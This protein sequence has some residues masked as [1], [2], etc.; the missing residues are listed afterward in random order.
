MQHLDKIFTEIYDQYVD[1]VFRFI[2]LKVSSQEI[3]QDLCSEVFL[4]YWKSLNLGTQIENPR[5]FLYQIAR[6]LVIDHYREKGK[7]P[8]IVPVENVRLVDSR[9]NLEKKFALKSDIDGI[10][11]ALNDLKDEYQD[12]I[13]WHYLEDFSISEIAEMM[14]KSDGAVRVALHRALKYLRANIEQKNKE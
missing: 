13:I 7:G 5:A 8:K 9:T 6:N 2:F 11:L 4:R 3:S 10:K 1:K 14:N 12:I